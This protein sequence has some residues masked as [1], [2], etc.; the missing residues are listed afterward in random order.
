HP[1]TGILTA[2]ELYDP[3][4]DTW[5]D[6]APMNVDRY[7]ATATLLQGGTVLVVGGTSNRDSYS[8]ELY[9]P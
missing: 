9:T 5:S 6:T 2:A 4:S 7:R 3:A 8:A 1:S